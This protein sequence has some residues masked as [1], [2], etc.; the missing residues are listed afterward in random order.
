MGALVLLDLGVEDGDATL[1]ALDHL[2]HQDRDVEDMDATLD[3]LDHQDLDVE[4]MD[5]VRA[6]QETMDL[7]VIL[8]VEY[9]ATVVLADPFLAMGEA[10]AAVEQ[11]KPKLW[12]RHDVKNSYFVSLTIMYTWQF[13]IFDF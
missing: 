12:N 1:V 7:L 11:T 4:E 6:A 5:A 9:L 2:G 3:L 10:V 8:S 13:K